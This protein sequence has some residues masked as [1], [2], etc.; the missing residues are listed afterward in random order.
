MNSDGTATGGFDTPAV[1]SLTAVVCTVP[2]GGFTTYDAG[3]QDRQLRSWAEETGI[4]RVKIKVGESWGESAARDAE[5]VS[6]ARR[7]IGGDLYVDANGAYTRKQAV[8]MA[9][10]LDAEGVTWFEEPVSSDDLAGLAHV[11]AQVASDVSAGEYGYTL[12]YFHHRLRHHGSERGDRAVAGYLRLSPPGVRTGVAG[13]GDTTRCRGRRS[14]SGATP[15][16]SVGRN[17]RGRPCGR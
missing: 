12:P 6:R 8:R 16:R 3:Q 17:R 15:Y 4:P 14:C 9:R 7:S 1:D 2:T 11:R 13:T 5:R 10:H